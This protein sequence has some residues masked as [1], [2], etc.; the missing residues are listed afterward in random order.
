MRT[1]NPRCEAIQ[2]EISNALDEGAPLPADALDHAATCPDCTAF[3]GAWTGRIDEILSG[4]M[5]PAG[6]ELRNEVLAYPERVSKLNSTRRRY[7]GYASAAAAAV[8]LGLLGY[9]LV[10]VRRGGTEVVKHPTAAQKE[11]VALKSDLRSGIAALRGPASAMQR[12]LRP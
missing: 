2:M 1:I 3:L 11:I 7:R 12:V 8:M 6:L 5:P 9:T 4:P 10:D